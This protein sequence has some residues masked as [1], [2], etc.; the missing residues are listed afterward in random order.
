[1]SPLLEP[2]K[3]LV[4]S[5]GTNWEMRKN[6]KLWKASEKKKK[7]C[8]LRA[9]STQELLHSFVAFLS[10]GTIHTNTLGIITSKSFILKE[11]HILVF[12]GPQI[13]WVSSYSG[14]N[15]SA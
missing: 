8:Y 9:T 14:N 5:L 6:R 7:D 1:M 3:M 15:Q 13:L 11:S 4:Q 2:P 12:Q 10:Q